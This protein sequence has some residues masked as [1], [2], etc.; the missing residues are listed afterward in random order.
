VTND[1]PGIPALLRR[2]RGIYAR[3]IASALAAAGLEDLPRNGPFVIGGMANHGGSAAEMIR[4]LGVSR[5]AASQLIDTLVLRGYLTR[6]V[7][8]EDRRRMDLELTDRGRAAAAVIR[9]AIERVD[10]QLAE[11]I[12]PG[13][14]AGLRAG[15][16]ALGTIKDGSEADAD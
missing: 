5:Q 8:A 13:E 16:T 11:M 2:A 7:N 9:S 3:T 14:L 10:R 12:S 4:G 6:E 1:P 15:L